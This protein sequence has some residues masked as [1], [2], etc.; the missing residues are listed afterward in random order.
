[1]IFE[2]NTVDIKAFKGFNQS[3]NYV[4]FDISVYTI[5][6]NGRESFTKILIG[7]DRYAMFR[8]GSIEVPYSLDIDTDRTVV[9][10]FQK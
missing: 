2:W 10:Y 9:A 6:R 5:G 8:T 1:M 3:L 7:H 4:Y